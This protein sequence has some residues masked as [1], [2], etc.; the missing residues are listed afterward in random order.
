M[1]MREGKAVEGVCLGQSSAKDDEVESLRIKLQRLKRSFQEKEG[2][3][4]ELIGRQYHPRNR[5]YKDE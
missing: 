5:R 1:S 4:D 3:I 2:T